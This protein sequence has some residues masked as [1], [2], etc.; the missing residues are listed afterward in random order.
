MILVL[1]Q[2]NEKLWLRENILHIRLQNLK[3]DGGDKFS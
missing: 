2:I 1:E 3:K